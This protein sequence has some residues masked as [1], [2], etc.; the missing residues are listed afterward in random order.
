MDCAASE[1]FDKEAGIY[2]MKGEGKTFTSEEFNHYLAELANNFPIVSIEDGLDES[3]WDGFK[4]QTELLGDKLQIVGDDLFV[5]N[6][7]ILAEGI[8]KGVGFFKGC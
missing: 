2:N 6:T 8:E 7:K 1:F 4:H 5:T 3:D